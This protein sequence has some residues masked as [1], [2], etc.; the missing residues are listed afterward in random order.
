MLGFFC[1]FH[2]PQ[3]FKSEFKLFQFKG[4][5]EKLTSDC[6]VLEILGPVPD[7]HQMALQWGQDPGRIIN[8]SIRPTP[9][10]CRASTGARQLALV[11]LTVVVAQDFV[12]VQL[13][14]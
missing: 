9:S 13:P 14:T 7:M 10:G 12:V 2:L 4:Y 1:L 5:K 8:P 6:D 11:L 3:N